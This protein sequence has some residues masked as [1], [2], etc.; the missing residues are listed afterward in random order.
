MMSSVCNS[1]PP[2]APRYLPIFK[3]KKLLILLNYLNNSPLRIYYKGFVI[4]STL[5]SNVFQKKL[6]VHFFFNKEI[7]STLGCLLAL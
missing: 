6:T 5:F 2:F 1:I 4:N 7:N 3:K